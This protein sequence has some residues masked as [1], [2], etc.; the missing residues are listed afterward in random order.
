MVPVDRPRAGARAEADREHPAPAPRAL[1]PSTDAALFA[2]LR[3]RPQPTSSI[4]LTSIWADSAV[5]PTS[6]NACAMT[7]WAALDPVT[8]AVSTPACVGSSITKLA[9]KPQ[10]ARRAFSL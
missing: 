8:S 4:E 6:S 2:A 9:I 3:R 10:R 1:Q 7:A 5:Y